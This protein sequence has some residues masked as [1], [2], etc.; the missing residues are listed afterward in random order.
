MKKTITFSL[1]AFF[2]FIILIE[3]F[4]RFLVFTISMNKDI[5]KFGFDKSIE[6]QIRKLSKFD[7]EVVNNKLE[8]INFENQLID[9]DIWT[10]GG[11]TSDIACRKQNNTSWPNELSN[12]KNSVFNFA[13]SGTNTDFALN[14]LI[15]AVN[16]GKKPKKILWANFVNETDV[17]FFGFKKNPHLANQVNSNIKLNKFVYFLKSIQLSLKKYSIAFYIL[18]DFSLRLMHKLKLSH[19]IYDLDKKLGQKELLVSAMNYYLNTTKA[20]SISN[21][22]GIKF[23]I[24]TLFDISDLSNENKFNDKEII[25]FKTIEKILNENK[26]IYWINL[27]KEQL[28]QDLDDK[29]KIFC[30]NIHFTTY[31][32]II[33]ADI[34]KNLIAN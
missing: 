9:N 16:S 27:K 11:S 21:K 23:F 28:L 17:V 33:V 15:A 14:S 30:D 2:L 24:I 26:N 29:N 8:K 22:L 34:I 25:F 5:F 4:S 12:K 32:N 1:I 3:F 13:K 6:L 31:G 7:F 10:F 18:D 20:I 19:L